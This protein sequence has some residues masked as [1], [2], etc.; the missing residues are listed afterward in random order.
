MYRK[1]NWMS[2]FFRRSFIAIQTELK[3]RH[4]TVTAV[5]WFPPQNMQNY[6]QEMQ[7]SVES[8]EVS[9]FA[10]TVRQKALVMKSFNLPFI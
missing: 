8:T 9:I 1:R 4:P 5:S 7:R 3:Y 6:S 2:D 10:S